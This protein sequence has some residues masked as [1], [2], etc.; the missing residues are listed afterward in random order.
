MREGKRKHGTV[1]GPHPKTAQAGMTMLKN[2]GNAIDAAIAAALTEGVV[3]PLH[4]GIA[5]YGGS[6]VIYNSK[7]SKVVA[8][9]CN[10]TAPIEASEKMFTIEQG[11]HPSV[12]RIPKRANVLGPLA[13][14]VPGVFAGL[15]LALQRFG[16][17][18]LK[19]VIR[20]AIRAARYGYVP[21][22][23][24][25]QGLLDNAQFWQQNFPETARVF[26]KEGRPPRKGQRV[27][28]PDLARTLEILAEGGLTSFY[29]GP[30]GKKIATYIQE[31]GGCLTTEDLQRYRAR[32]V[33]PYQSTYRD[34]QLFTPPLAAG[35][36][37]TLQILRLLEPYDLGEKNQIDR[38]HHL[39][40]AMKICWPER[41]KRYGDPSFVDI[42]VE[43]ELSKEFMARLGRRFRDHLKRPRPGRLVAPEPINC[44]SHI[45]TADTSGN[46][47]SLTQTHGGWYG[48][49]ITVPGT[50]LLLGHGISRFDPRPGL[51][52]SIAPGKQ[53]LHNMAPFIA[54]RNGR[55][56]A[57]YGLPGGRTIP[58]NQVTLTVGL[59]DRNLDPQK[60][61][62]A[63]RLHTEGT[64]PLQIERR[65][66][67]AVMQ[68][69]CKLGHRVDFADGIGGPGHIV[70]VTDA[71]DIQVGATDSRFDGLALS[72]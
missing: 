14:G 28:N 30:I 15:C 71:P 16:T 11:S 7:R 39:A 65:A 59:I 35:G 4:N 62:N 8:I 46:M 37:T 22:L 42:D 68:G 70:T 27:T 66:G 56:F 25:R 51:A 23:K 53:P 50:G 17:M 10:S 20:P 32:L 54:L 72:S 41:L 36:L 67:K 6:M 61:L 1:A 18:P 69:L 31:L 57:T 58:N 43:A 12:Y 38:L 5:G 21:G 49:M 9:D 26:L 33:E 63:T 44:T 60:A 29:N 48:S 64:E 45:S 34:C 40:E 24:N 47:V 55:P 2:G 52:N 3:E 13:V 19:E